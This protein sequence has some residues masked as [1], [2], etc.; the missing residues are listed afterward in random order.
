MYL[1]VFLHGS[2]RSRRDPLIRVK[3]NGVIR[4]LKRELE[5]RTQIPADGQN[6]QFVDAVCYDEVPLSLLA[7]RCLSF[8]QPFGVEEHMGDLRA[9]YRD[10]PM[11]RMRFLS[12][13]ECGSSRSPRFDERELEWPLEVRSRICQL[14]GSCSSMMSS[15]VQQ[16]SSSCVRSGSGSGDECPSDSASGGSGTSGSSG[17]ASG[18]CTQAASRKCCPPGQVL[19]END[20]CH[21]KCDVLCCVAEQ[22]DRPPY[23][24]VMPEDRRFGLVITN[25]EDPCDC[26]FNCILVFL[27]EQFHL[28]EDAASLKFSQCTSAVA[29]DCALLIVCE[30]SGTSDW[31]LNA[32]RPMCPP[33]KCTSLIKHFDMVR[34]TFVIPMVINRALCRIFNVIEKQN[35]GL[36][37]S[38]WCVMSKTALDPCSAEYPSKVIYDDAINYEIVAYIDKESQE[39]IDKHCHKIR[40][41]MWHLPVDFCHSSACSKI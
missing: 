40:Y 3:P 23:A 16:S 11:F 17:S 36:D 19:D 24:S 32:T 30:D 22:G 41:M 4:D 29:F 38:K 33:F 26:D 28:A 39:Y 31:V 27:V 9:F 20:S 14:V 1:R 21:S 12:D 2:E 37:T 8:G 13:A 34:C 18:G 35:C 10:I 7:S 6:I 15:S 5:K 25:D